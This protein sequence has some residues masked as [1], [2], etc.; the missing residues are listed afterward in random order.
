MSEF[1][2][3]EVPYSKTVAISGWMGRH[4]Q[5]MERN[6]RCPHDFAKLEI[7]NKKNFNWELYTKYLYEELIVCPKCGH[8]IGDGYIRYLKEEIAKDKGRTVFDAIKE[9]Q[10]C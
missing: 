1:R 10:K 4:S 9:I 3:F 2:L 7:P 8:K 6:Y 5:I